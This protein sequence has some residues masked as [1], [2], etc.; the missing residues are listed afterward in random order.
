MAFENNES[1]NA[2][3]DDEMES[4]ALLRLKRIAQEAREERRAAKQERELLAYVG[5]FDGEMMDQAL[6]E[7]ELKLEM[8]LAKRRGG[9]AWWPTKREMTLR[10]LRRR[11]CARHG[12]RRVAQ[13]TCRDWMASPRCRNP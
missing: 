11:T 5:A 12:F 7:R 9:D 8:D 4:L 3:G 1:F 13:T 10:R 2:N 6:V